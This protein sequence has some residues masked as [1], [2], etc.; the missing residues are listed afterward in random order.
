MGSSKAPD[1]SCALKKITDLKGL[2][3]TFFKKARQLY[4]TK[5]P[6]VYLQ[7]V[8]L[9]KYILPLIDLTSAQRLVPTRNSLPV[10]IYVKY[11]LSGIG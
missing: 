2:S 1:F 10:D 11:L 5:G 3:T 9:T 4:F 6:P 8:V 7:G